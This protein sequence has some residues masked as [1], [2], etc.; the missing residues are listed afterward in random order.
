MILDVS[1]LAVSGLV[2]PAEWV[3]DYVQLLIDLRA[4]LRERRLWEEADRVRDGLASLGVALRDTRS[5]TTWHM[6][7]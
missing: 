7:A 4:G 3:G 6:E 1:E 2:T 5:G